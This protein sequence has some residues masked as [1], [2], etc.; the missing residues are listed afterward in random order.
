MK[1]KTWIDSLLA[2]HHAKCTFTKCQ[3]GKC[4]LAK[5][6]PNGNMVPYCTS[7]LPRKNYS[8]WTDHYQP[9]I[10]CVKYW[11][12]VTY[13][14]LGWNYVLFNVLY[15]HFLT[16]LNDSATLRI[17]AN[18]ALFCSSYNGT[19]TQIIS[20]P[21]FFFLI[22]YFY[23]I[24]YFAWFSSLTLFSALLFHF[25]YQIVFLWFSSFL[26]TYVCYSPSLMK[27]AKLA[28]S[29]KLLWN[30]IFSRKFTNIA[31]MCSFSSYTLY[32]SIYF[33]Q[34]AQK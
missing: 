26:F 31:Y 24:S 1:N 33:L 25:S 23:I 4:G 5:K 20:L 32:T 2:T 22:F 9:G 11:T 12:V 29:Q 34:L 3:S 19:M 6:T 16:S 30:L 13:L 7:W 14:L 17:L 8:V 27:F 21:S 10:C 15:T 28:S 18:E